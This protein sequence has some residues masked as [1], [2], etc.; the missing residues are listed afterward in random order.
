VPVSG[1]WLKFSD[2]A[3][4]IRTY[5]PER[6]YWIHDALLNSKGANL[7]TNL[8]NLAP[9]ASGPATFLVPGTSLEL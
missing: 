1:P 9:T 6:G 5:A 2:V 4:Y 7:L 8:L 3:D